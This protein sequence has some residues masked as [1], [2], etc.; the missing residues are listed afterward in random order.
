[1][2]QG[3]FYC[4]YFSVKLIIVNVAF[5][6]LF[7]NAGSLELQAFLLPIHCIKHDALTLRLC[8]H[9]AAYLLAPIVRQSQTL[10]HV[11]K[12]RTYQITTKHQMP[13]C[14]AGNTPFSCGVSV[15]FIISGR[16]FAL[17]AK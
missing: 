2:M 4:R 13:S 8:D 17:C 7:E 12:L 16:A 1:M 10:E 11:P 5:P 14:R 6:M 15:V 3:K 9:L